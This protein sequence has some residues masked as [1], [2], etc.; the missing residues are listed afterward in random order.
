MPALTPTYLLAL[1]LPPSPN[2]VEQDVGRHQDGVAEEPDSDRLLVGNL[3]A[4]LLVLD[5][6][7]HC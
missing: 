1:A 5:H 4:L 3:G 2:L 6:L 7:L